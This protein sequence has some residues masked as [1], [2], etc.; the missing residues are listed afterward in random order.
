MQGGDDLEVD[1][2]QAVIPTRF[3]IG[4]KTISVFSTVAQFG[5]VQ[6]LVMAD[7]KAELMF[8]LDE[9]SRQYFDG[10]PEV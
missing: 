2:L 10:K 8:L 3:K 7:L 5:T 6:D 4:E 1:R 9:V